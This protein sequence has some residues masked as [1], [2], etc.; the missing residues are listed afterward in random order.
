MI[1]WQEGGNVEEIS[2]GWGGDI[3]NGSPDGGGARLYPPQPIGVI[4][5]FIGNLFDR[6]HVGVRLW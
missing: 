3:C 5:L 6:G 1:E 4:A 2:P